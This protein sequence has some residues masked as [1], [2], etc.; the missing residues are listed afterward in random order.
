MQWSRRKVLASGVAAPLAAAFA[1]PADAA[2]HATGR[3]GSRQRFEALRG[4]TFLLRGNEPGEGPDLHATLSRIDPEHAEDDSDDGCFALHFDIAHSG[5]A[6]QSIYTVRHPALETFAV[7]A[8]PS[9]AD[10]RSLAVV[11]NSPR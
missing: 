6:V 7:L 1:P 9:S 3:I 5:G 10:G 2:L 4:Q 8:V 11:F